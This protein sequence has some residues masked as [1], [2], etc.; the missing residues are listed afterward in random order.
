MQRKSAEEVMFEAVKEKY[1]Q[2]KD[3]QE[4]IFAINAF[5]PPIRDSDPSF[6]A[7]SI[8]LKSQIKI[9]Y[10]Q[11]SNYL[12]I[13]KEEAMDFFKQGRLEENIQ[14]NK[15]NLSAHQAVIPNKLD[16]EKYAK[17][18]QEFGFNE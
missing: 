11:L 18:E 1:F 10:F 9:P 4:I 12:E 3:T 15:A 17:I 13:S 7:Y 8:T 16:L 6:L 5:G 14:D 2:H